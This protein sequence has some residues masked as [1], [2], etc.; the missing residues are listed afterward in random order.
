METDKKTIV[1]GAVPYPDRYA[2]LATE[3]LKAHGHTVIP[4]GIRPGMIAG[5]PIQQ[6]NPPVEN[7]DTI[8]LYLNPERQVPLY[9][10]ILS[11][12]PRRILFNPGT[13]NPELVKLA[14]EK[15]I[16]TEYAC[17]LVL[18]ASSQY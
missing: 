12:K 3:R 5:I 4:V 7:V 17:T 13:E 6:G 8:T 16:D 9:D 2:Y 18:L 14:R 1:L 11:L 15:G 10:Y